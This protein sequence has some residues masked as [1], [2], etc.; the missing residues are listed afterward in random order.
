MSQGV[1]AYLLSVVSAAMLA[2]IVQTLL[3]KG[4]VRRVS[5][6]ACGIVLILVTLAPLR[7]MDGSAVARA[8]ARFQIEQDEAASGVEVRSRELI[9]ALIKEKSEAYILDMAGELG[10]ELSVEVTVES[11]GAYPYPVFVR[12]TGHAEAESRRVMTER[13]EENLAIPASAQEWNLS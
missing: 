12:L 2:A 7:G 1:Q 11:A 6:M 5:T 10:A 8:I 4:A 9:A 3:P 13:I